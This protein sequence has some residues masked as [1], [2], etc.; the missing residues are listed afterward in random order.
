MLK[1]A[2]DQGA[3][4]AGPDIDRLRASLTQIVGV[5]AV[6]ADLA[7]RRLHSQDIWSEA[8]ETV[9]LV[10]RPTDLSDLAEVLTAAHGAGWAIAPR[11][12]GMSYTSAYI[13]TRPHTISLDLSAL[14]KVLEIDPDNM[15]VTVQAGC[16]WAALDAALAPLGLRTPF[17]G[18]MSGL[19]STIGGGLS[20]LNAMFGAGHYGTSSESVVG[21]TIVLA[22]GRILRTGAR[23]EGRN[24]FYRHYG[25][26]LTG[27]FC[28]DAGVFGIKAE[29]TLRLMRRPEHEG[30]ASF[31]FPSGPELLSAMSEMARAG[32]ACEMCGFDPG[33][34]KVRM[35]RAA[36]ASDLKVLG[37][38]VAKEK[39]LGRGL[40]SAAKIAMG[41]R[42][43]IEA[44]EYSVHVVC[45]GRSKSGVDADLDAARA[46]AKA[47]G[48]REI[49]NTIAKVIR[50]NPFPPLNSMIGPDGERWAPVHGV[51]S[52][53]RA[54]ALFTRIQALFAEMAAA[55]EDHGVYCGYL[56]TSMS[57]NALI[58]EPVFYWP[59]VR[60]ALIDGSVEPQ[61]LAKLPKLPPNPEATALVAE[62]RR[63]VIDICAS[64]GCGH[65]QIGRSYPY[66]QSRDEASWALIEAL[67]AAL[68]AGGALNPDG[69]GLSVD[70]AP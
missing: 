4:P 30:Y 66:R 53:A 8:S 24:P 3:P 25:P 34:T 70:R 56:F 46:I 68:D 10:V 5:D 52:H 17:W 47:R 64:L 9:D 45:E 43:F 29:V 13:P 39:S 38:V 11:G 61:H 40:L 44:E 31:A 42:N 32:L 16:T 12:G 57:T 48:G 55:F 50:A 37:A 28:G 15:T 23:E 62:A 51:V 33:L 14:N 1:T 2:A 60:Q 41:G 54:A 65:F 19:T 20:Q 58:I 22:D 35:R 21:L 26:D 27:L 59:E 49:E 63:K 6:S 7:D 36:L 18:P 69:L 67:K